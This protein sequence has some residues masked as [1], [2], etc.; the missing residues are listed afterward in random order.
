MYDC[1]KYYALIIILFLLLIKNI[2]I[3]NKM[4]VS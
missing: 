3:Q 1:V 4:T 2:F